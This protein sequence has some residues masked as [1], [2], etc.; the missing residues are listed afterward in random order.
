M[1]SKP[2]SHSYEPVHFVVCGGG[3]FLCGGTHPR[4]QRAVVSTGDGVGQPWGK[5]LKEQG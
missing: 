2:L 5:E 4:P 1:L 3:W